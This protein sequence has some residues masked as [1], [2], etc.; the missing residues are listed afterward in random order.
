MNINRSQF[1]AITIAVLGV[2]MVS[3]SQLTDLFGP[4][5]TKSIVSVASILN[6]ILGS[7]LAVIT[8]QGGQVRDVLAM[9]GVEKIN[10]NANANQ[11]LAAIAIDPT[12]N[13]ISPT[14]AAQAAVTATAQ[15]NS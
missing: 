11:T 1:I 3:T 2:L 4:T 6:S 15:G 7:A 12:I 9:P 14:P 5:V 13:K 10:V 8:S